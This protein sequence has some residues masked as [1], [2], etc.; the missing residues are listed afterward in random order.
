[1]IVGALQ[2]ARSTASAALITVRAGNL[3]M[4]AHVDYSDVGQSSVPQLGTVLPGP[5]SYNVLNQ[6][7]RRLHR[8]STCS[9]VTTRRRPVDVSPMRRVL[10]DRASRQP[11]PTVGM[12]AC[13]ILTSE[14]P[15]LMGRSH[16]VTCQQHRPD[17]YTTTSARNAGSAGAAAG[18]PRRR[19]SENSEG[20]AAEI[21]DAAGVLFARRALKTTVEKLPRKQAPPGDGMGTKTGAVLWAV[22]TGPNVC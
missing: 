17:P 21:L 22:V 2:N 5:S 14:R 8:T 13:E 16:T 19:A 1:M 10:V 18:R 7:R 15:G 6:C 4:F 11:A 9:E 20:S 12:G 3:P